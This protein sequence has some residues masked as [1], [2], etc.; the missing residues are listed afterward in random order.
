M[1][2]SAVEEG[3]NA[4]IGYKKKF[5]IVRHHNYECHPLKDRIAKPILECSN[6]VVEEL[7]KGKRVDEAVKKS[8]EKSAD[9]I[10]ELIYS[11]EPLAIASLQAVIANDSALDFKGLPSEKIC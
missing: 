9:Y 1:G 2:K 5:W 10:L 7:I 4:F 8:H 6:V 3:C 11:K